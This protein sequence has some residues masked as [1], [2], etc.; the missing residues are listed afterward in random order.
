MQKPDYKYLVMEN[1]SNNNLVDQATDDSIQELSKVKAKFELEEQKLKVDELKLKIR[2]LKRPE[3]S[4]LNFW[5][6]MAAVI[7]AIGGIIGQNY[8]SSIKSERAQ[9]DVIKAMAKKDTAERIVRKAKGDLKLVERRAKALHDSIGDAQLAYNNLKQEAARLL[10]G[11]GSDLPKTPKNIAKIKEVSN[12]LEYI[13]TN[14]KFTYNNKYIPN[15]AIKILDSN[16]KEVNLT[17][18]IRLRELNDAEREINWTAY[19]PQG[20]YYIS[21]QDKL[22]KVL[23]DSLKLSFSKGEVNAGYTTRTIQLVLK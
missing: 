18:G 10:K 4:R 20:T 14:I 8:L 19:L 16:K 12:I 3:Y 17:P 5:T 11:L 13:R 21:V 7:I 15:I 22:Y 6:S 23:G 2:E 9:L 1:E